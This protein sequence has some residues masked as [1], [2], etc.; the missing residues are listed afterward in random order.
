MVFSV[1]YDPSPEAYALL[2]IANAMVSRLD[3]DAITAT[4]AIR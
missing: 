1:A 3:K 2:G 4:A